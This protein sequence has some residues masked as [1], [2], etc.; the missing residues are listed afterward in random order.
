MKRLW[1]LL[2]VLLLI[3]CLT[4]VASAKVTKG[5]CGENLTWIHDS[6]EY[7]LTISGTGK[8]EDYA[9]GEDTPWWG[10]GIVSNEYSFSTL[11]IE[12]GVTSVGKN[13]FSG[14]YV[15]EVKLPNG[16]TE[17]RDGAFKNCYFLESVYIPASVEKIGSKVF[18]YCNNLEDIYY[19]GTSAQRKKIDSSS[20][21]S[22]AEWHYKYIE[23]PK[24]EVVTGDTEKPIVRWERCSFATSYRI[25]RKNGSKGEY[26]LLAKTRRLK[27]RDA[28]AQAGKTYYYKVKAV[29][30]NLEKTSA[31]SNEEKIFCVLPEPKVT[32]KGDAA[33]G[34]PKLTWEKVPG[35]KEYWVGRG[36]YNYFTEGFKVT[37]TTFLDETAKPGQR[38]WYYVEAV[39]ENEKAN[40]QTW[41]DIGRVCDLPRPDV[42]IFLKDGDPRIKWDAIEEA[43]S[44]MVYRA[45]SE[46]G[47]YTLVKTTKT[48][49]SYTDTDA[50]AGKT[51]YYRVKA[52]HKAKGADSALSLVKS[53]TA[54]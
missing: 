21:T 33:T 28:S 15:D 14:C 53:I 42:K 32:I 27:Y 50:E 41:D 40:T 5:K 22:G 52:T 39:C 13:A 10:D 8:M 17:I 30:G 2:L 3:P 38:Y 6:K 35:A 19:G 4:V 26:K 24:I 31:Y 20:S 11:V 34:K 1:S 16:L 54:E 51:Y 49:T 37:G 36:D 7:T 25:Y 9:S 29:D 48:A 18:L 44:Y 23:K 12:E 46:K 47:E 43:E 45:T